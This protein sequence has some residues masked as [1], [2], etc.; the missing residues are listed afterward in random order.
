MHIDHIFFINSSFQGHLGCFHRL[1]IVSRAAID[2][3]TD[4]YK[5]NQLCGF[6]YQFLKS[7]FSKEMGAV[8]K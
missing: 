3:E 6:M 5:S 4:T 2:V 8:N 1:A 7:H